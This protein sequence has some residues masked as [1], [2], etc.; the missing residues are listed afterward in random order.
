MRLWIIALFLCLNTAEAVADPY[1]L[2]ASVLPNSRTGQ[3][4]DTLTYFAAV[5]NSGENGLT[6]C[7]I[8]AFYPAPSPWA[9]VEIDF[10]PINQDGSPRNDE[11]PN[12][13]DIEAGATEFFVLTARA[14]Y[15]DPELATMEGPGSI[16]V[17]CPHPE[18]SRPAEYVIAT[19][20]RAMALTAHFISDREPPDVIP[21]IVSPTGDGI[22]TLDPGTGRGVAAAAAVNIGPDAE[23]LVRADALADVAATICQSDEA[24]IC[25]APRAAEIRV[26]MPRNVPLYFS[27]LV[28]DGSSRPTTFRPAWRRLSLEFAEVMDG[29][30]SAIRQSRTTT[31]LA[32]RD[33]DPESVPATPYGY[34]AGGLDLII[35][36]DN[37][38]LDLGDDF[39]DLGAGYVDLIDIDEH[40]VT[41]SYQASGPTIDGMFVRASGGPSTFQITPDDRLR[42][43]GPQGET[44]DYFFERPLRQVS[45]WSGI[46][47]SISTTNLSPERPG[48]ATLTHGGGMEIRYNTT[49]SRYGDEVCRLVGSFYPV[50]IGVAESEIARF[51]GQVYDC[52]DDIGA[53]GGWMIVT[54]AMADGGQPDAI[55][56]VTNRDVSD[57]TIGLHLRRQAQ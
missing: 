47:T 19:G 30:F 33:G 22:L 1:R 13:F 43:V 20:G 53:V 3:T 35:L 45:S 38:V 5:T 37:H 56:L 21:I 46:Y 31:S 17:F 11:L 42:L 10:A 9:R 27:V 32:I 40:D 52:F 24:G 49:S 23:F 54:G 36:P 50:R 4:G 16:L 48:G 25:Q 57:N 15:T 2:V 44:W 8:D 18:P 26:S 55:T 34:W 6:R 51:T 12:L 39:R 14:V 41:W 7:S 28:Q 29:R